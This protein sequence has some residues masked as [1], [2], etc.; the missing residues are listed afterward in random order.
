MK[1]FVGLVTLVAT[2]AAV[3]NYFRMP[4]PYR[5]SCTAEEKCVREEFN[6]PLQ[7]EQEQSQNQQNIQN[8]QNQ[9][10]FDQQSR[11][12]TTL[13]ECNLVCGQYGSLWPQPSK[14]VQMADET[15]R[16]VPQ[17]IRFSKVSA[18]DQ[19]VE[20]MLMEQAHYFQRNLHF[21]HPNYPRKSKGPFTEYQEE[22]FQNYDQRQRNFKQSERRFRP[23][24]GGDDRFQGEEFSS[25]V[26]RFDL[27][28]LNNRGRR[29]PTQEQSQ[30]K[31]QRPRF[32]RQSRSRDQM[33]YERISP[34]SKQ[35]AS[36]MA[37]RQYFDV[38]VTV[39][40]K[41]T[42]LRL[43]TD[44]SYDLTVQTIGDTTTATIL[45]SEYY[46]ARH[47]LETL[48]QLIDYDE[49]SNSLQ[50]VKTAKISDEPSFKYRGLL[51]DTGRN[52]Y[53]KEEIL[54]LLDTMSTNKLNTFHW[55]MSDSTSFPMYSQRQPQMTL[56]GAY[57]P[58]KVYYPQDVRE[59][60]E[61]AN[62]RGIRVVPELDGPAHSGAGYNFGE[63]AGKGKL[64]LCNEPEDVW[65]DNCKE[66]PCGQMNPVNPELYNVLKNIY[67][68]MLESF[69]PEFLHMG[70]D[71]TS[72]K[73]WSNSQEIIDFLTKQNREVNSRELFELWN[74]YQKQAYAKFTEAQQETGITKPVKPMI[75]SSSFVRNYID[76]K[77]Y[78]VTLTSVANAS[79][80][81]Q[82]I[83]K[84]YDVVFA[85]ADVWT[86]DGPAASWVSQAQPYIASAEVPR[87]TWKQV[88][89]NSPLDMISHLEGTNS[90]VTPLRSNLP[91]VLG[92]EGTVWSYETDAESLQ[93]TLWPRAAALAE[94]LWTDVPQFYQQA[95][96]VES[97][98]AT[99]R[100][101]MVS[102]GTR[103]EVFQPEYC[104]Q[105]QDSC[106][107]QEFK[108]ALDS[109]A[110]SYTQE[111][112][113]RLD[114]AA[115]SHRQ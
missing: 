82:Y 14:E 90:A 110:I 31:S 79:D 59:I 43:D 107:S 98:F 41:E 47:A 34:F 95:D 18:G 21:M 7:Q 2:V 26:A 70:G 92:G 113:S 99:H 51:L 46:G 78:I 12:Y 54:S 115:F 45:A 85:N 37:E 111:R 25:N 65:Y 73:C 55:R 84:G 60:V 4:S 15:V 75:Y 64:V 87:P 69:N 109:G 86:F 103:A 52:F 53:P 80:I 89:E 112:P 76:P 8:Q 91:N 13:E 50:V 108:Q 6:A 22:R 66:A 72:F 93:S 56:Y 114:P 100:E 39:T 20:E 57:A 61:Y 17:N 58:R 27:F 81:E 40:G 102:R 35:Q 48:S 88:Y 68:D 32:D 101:R 1:V 77:E 3:E 105:N 83:T 67:S 71:D 28:D 33:R 9:Q 63:Q 104:F 16:F 10:R 38:E 97:R 29:E 19:E 49:L 96:L 94:R 36:P 42:Q 24:M 44:E 62:Q 30:L 74:T 5:Y 11:K 106:Y 23:H